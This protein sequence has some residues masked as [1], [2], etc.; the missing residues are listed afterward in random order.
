MENEK[1]EH[2]SELLHLR[3]LLAGVKC[4]SSELMDLRQ[5]LDSKHAQELEE[6]RTY[7]EQKC[8]DLEKQ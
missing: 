1:T 2:E 5:E 3:E 6:L 7:F 8:T 4:G